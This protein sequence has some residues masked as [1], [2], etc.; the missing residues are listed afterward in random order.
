MGWTCP[1]LY[2]KKACYYEKKIAKNN[3]KIA[4]LEEENKIYA[5]KIAGQKQD[6]PSVTKD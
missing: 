5:E 3:K 4:S 6:T 2:G 1:P